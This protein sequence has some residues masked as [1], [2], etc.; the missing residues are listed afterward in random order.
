[1]KFKKKIGVF[2]GQ[3]CGL[4]NRFA[5]RLIAGVWESGYMQDE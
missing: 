3:K 4:L 2:Q 1:M 5:N